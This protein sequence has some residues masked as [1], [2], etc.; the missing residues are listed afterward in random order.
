MRWQ[1]KAMEAA[2]F[3]DPLSCAAKKSACLQM[4]GGPLSGLAQGFRLQA[5]KIVSRGNIWHNSKFPAPVTPPGR[6]P[7]NTSLTGLFLIGN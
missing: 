4:P 7:C 2:R 1:N 5:Y 6:T 3:A